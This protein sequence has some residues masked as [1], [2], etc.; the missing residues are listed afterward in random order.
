[1]TCLDSAKRRN[2]SSLVFTFEPHPTKILRPEK[3]PL[4]LFSR[5]EKRQWLR[6]LGFEFILEQTFDSD[7]RKI[8]AEKFID[9]ILRKKLQAKVISIGPNFRFG[10]EGRGTVDLLK[11]Q[12]D[13]EIIEV[14]PVIQDGVV[15]SSSRIR[16]LVSLG[17]IEAAN[18]YLG[19]PY[20]LSGTVERGFERGEKLGF[21]TA[22]IKTDRECLP[23]D[24]V[25]ITI[26]EDLESSQ[27]FTSASNIG[28]NP[29]FENKQRSIE[30]H[31][32]DFNDSLY[33]RRVRLFFLK[34]L[35]SEMKFKDL[36][37]LKAQI[38]Q[39]IQESRNF[40]H[41]MNLLRPP[42]ENNSL[43]LSHVDFLTQRFQTYG[44]P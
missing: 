28:F 3:A 18:R 44:T 12:T 13:F 8:S 17:E 38:S 7:F 26:L 11:K 22:N 19:H 4:L 39:D 41:S 6:H 1:M 27:F 9:E 35:R 14:A 32:L 23:K 31:L 24:G 34:H 10:F 21:P 43:S 40:F 25:Y 30:A 2:L 15:L 5:D 37:L 20:F 33:E 36:S 16:E 42:T 29:S